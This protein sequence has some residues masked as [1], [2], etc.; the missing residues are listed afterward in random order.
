KSQSFRSPTALELLFS[1]V[2]KRKVTKREGHPAW[3][4]PPLHGRQVREPGPGFF[5]RA[6]CPREKAS[7]SMDSPAA[8]PVVPDSPP[9]RGPGQSSGPSWPALGAQPLRGCESRARLAKGTS[10]IGQERTL[11]VSPDSCSRPAISTPSFGGREDHASQNIRTNCLLGSNRRILVPD[12]RVVVH[13]RRP[14]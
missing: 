1:C 4:L 8:R 11:F 7:P 10:S 9:H 14:V 3:R 12:D 13:Q 2:A 6:S 5:E